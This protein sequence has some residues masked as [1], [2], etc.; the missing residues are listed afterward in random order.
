MDQFL[1]ADW[2]MKYAVR[3]ATSTVTAKG[4]V[5]NGVMTP[6]FCTQRRILSE[7]YIYGHQQNATTYLRFLL[8]LSMSIKA[9]HLA[10]KV[11]IQILI[12]SINCV[13]FYVRI[14]R[15]TGEISD[16]TSLRA[17]CGTKTCM[18]HVSRMISCKP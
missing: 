9:I 13:S 15:A 12:I 10:S 6:I 16:S 3:T 8:F 2:K 17:T 18:P 7:Y 1:D 14:H 11:C 5:G 4:T